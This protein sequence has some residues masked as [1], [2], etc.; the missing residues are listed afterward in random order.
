MVGLERKGRRECDFGFVGTAI[1]S[2]FV[3]KALV[4]TGVIF[5]KPPSHIMPSDIANSTSPLP[6]QLHRILTDRWRVRSIEQGILRREFK[7]C[8]PAPSQ[9]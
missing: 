5:E 4:R 2:G 9:Y 3:A 1:C 7:P 8:D 6:K